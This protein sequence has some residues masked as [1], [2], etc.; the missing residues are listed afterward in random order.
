MKAS[1]EL[2]QRV[3]RAAGLCSKEEI[4]SAVGYYTDLHEKLAMYQAA[5]NYL[6][7]GLTVPSILRDLD[8]Y[9]KRFEGK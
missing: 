4:M 5:H 7:Q 3:A 2:L 1:K 9:V 8:Y 6:P